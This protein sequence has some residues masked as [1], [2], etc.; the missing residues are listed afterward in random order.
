M[1]I[2]NQR[3]MRRLR[4]LKLGQCHRN[5]KN[6]KANGNRQRK[7]KDNDDAIC[8]NTLN[9]LIKEV[10]LAL[11]FY[12][13]I[14]A[15]TD[16]HSLLVLANEGFATWS[17]ID[18]GPIVHLFTCRRV[19]KESLEHENTGNCE[20]SSR[21]NLTR[22]PRQIFD[23]QIRKDLYLY[24]KPYAQL[25]SMS[26]TTSMRKSIFFEL[27][28]CSS[29]EPNTCNPWNPVYSTPTLFLSNEPM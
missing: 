6:N 12:D 5:L 27:T 16:A 7:E 10:Q 21:Y 25:L 22:R 29:R 13:L 3:S 26:Q 28:R 8:T 9:C 11:R 15:R 18:L 23:A 4:P 17:F 24:S 20:T 19:N 2:D 14:S 1:R